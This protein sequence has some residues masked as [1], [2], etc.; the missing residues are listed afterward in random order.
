MEYISLEQRMLHAVAQYEI[1]YHE[2]E[3]M[4]ANIDY[5]AMM[6]DIELEEEEP[7]VEI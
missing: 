7:N 4:N 3:K 5:I 2:M 1:L 6:S